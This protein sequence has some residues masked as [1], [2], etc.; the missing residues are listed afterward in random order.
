MGFSTL[1]LCARV[2]CILVL[3]YF[4]AIF[5]YGIKDSSGVRVFC[6]AVLFFRPCVFV[7]LRPPFSAFSFIFLSSLPAFFHC[8][9]PVVGAL[10]LTAFRHKSCHWLL[11]F[12][13]HPLIHCQ[14]PLFCRVPPQNMLPVPLVLPSPSI[15]PMPPF[16]SSP[17]SS[18][19]LPSPLPCLLGVAAAT[20]LVLLLAEIFSSAFPL[21]GVLYFPSRLTLQWRCFRRPVPANIL[22][23]TGIAAPALVA[24]TLLL[25]VSAGP[26]PVSEV[27]W[28]GATT[29]F[30]FWWWISSVLPVVVV[31]LCDWYGG[32]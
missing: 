24:C 7:H 21:L 6:S 1:N 4:S 26:L 12:H 22:W 31:Q 29:C 8:L 15:P 18:G 27:F 3:L 17:T 25:S 28:C 19:L 23:L 11:W 13:W 5:Q 14:C 9:Q 32:F 20:L 30:F 2:V 10:R 16:G